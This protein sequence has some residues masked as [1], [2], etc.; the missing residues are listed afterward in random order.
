VNAEG[1]SVILHGGAR[2]IA[3]HD[4]EANRRGALAAL[5]AAT[6]MLEG[7]A[8]ALDACEAGVRALEDDQIFNAGA[9]A[10]RN[11]AGEIELDA[12]IM[13]GATLDIG[14]VGA[15]KGVANPIGVARVLLREEATL[16]VGDGARQ[17]A[18]AHGLINARDR[19]EHAGAG[20]KDT[21]GC[22]VRDRAGGLA[23]GISTGGLEGALPG[24]I[25]DAPLPGCGFYADDQAGAACFSGDGERIS[26]T[27]LAAR[28]IAALERDQ[29][30]QGAADLSLR[31]LLRVGGEAGA[32]VMNKSGEL[33][34][35]HSSDHFTVAMQTSRTSAQVFLK[36]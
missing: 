26:R 5:A 17:I 1:W 33:G 4:Q 19:R 12:A 11:K 23:V 31:F 21:V 16:V 7:G 3:P 6:Q 24:R 36:R 22:I 14:A 10:V 30:A 13:D 35:A 32:I 29:D 25:G 18:Q 28:A 9:G 20:G 15:L 8:P 27:L 2:T 34:W